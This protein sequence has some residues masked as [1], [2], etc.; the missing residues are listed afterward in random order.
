MERIIDLTFGEM[1]YD[2]SWVK[3][4]NVLLFGKSYDIRIVAEAYTGQDILEIQQKSYERYKREYLGYIA[5]IPSVLLDY[6]INNYKS[7][8]SKVDIP[9]KINLKNIN[10]EIIVKLIRVKTVYFDRKGQYGWL[11]DCAWD[12]E[13]GIS[14]ILSAEEPFVTE[15]DYLL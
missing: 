10:K 14:I 4:E 9:E 8:S 7:I 3:E 1:E 12:T 5:K 6:Y 2:H 13:H 15:Q 11:C